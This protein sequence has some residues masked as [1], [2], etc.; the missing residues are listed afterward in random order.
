MGERY[1]PTGTPITPH[2]REILTILQE[3]AAEVIVAISKIL[4]FGRNNSHPTTG[5]NNIYT[6]GI[7]VGHLQCMLSKAEAAELFFE[8]D[9]ETGWNEKEDKLAIFMQTSADD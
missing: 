4:R 7:E 1:Q 9:S 3:E 6:L 2:D 8:A 5:E